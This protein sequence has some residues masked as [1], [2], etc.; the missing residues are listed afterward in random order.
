[1]FSDTADR[2]TAVAY[3]L[4][5]VVPLVGLGVVL[6][7]YVLAPIAAPNDLL[8]V[9][10][11]RW[12]LA[13]FASISIL[14]LSCFFMLRRLV[15]RSLEENRVLA[16][17]DSLTGLPN[18]RMYEDRLEQVL[19]QARRHGRLVATCFLDLDGF[20]RINDTLGHSSGDRLLC[21]VAERLMAS[22]RRSDSIAR[23]RADRGQPA[24]SRLGGDEFTFL[25]NQISDAQDAGRVAHRIL[26]ALREPFRVDHHEVFVTGSIGIA[27]FPFD[28]ADT[29]TL[30][31][32]ADTAMYWA[33]DRG[34]NNYQF[35]SRFM[36]EAAERKLELEG[37]LRRALK[38]DD[39]SLSYQPVRNTASG[40][41]VGAE[42]LLRWVDP[43]S[44]PVSPSEFVPI[45]EDTGLIVAIGEWVLRTACAQARAWQDSGLEPIRMAVNVSGHQLRQPT[46]LEAVAESLRHSGLG[47]GCLEIEI[48]ESTIMQNDGVTV[49]ACRRLDEM[50]V[51]LVLDDFGTGYSSLSTLRRFPIGRL[52]IDRSFVSDLPA[53]RDDAALTSG[54]IA[55]AHSLGLQ[56]VAEGVET[57][58]QADFLRDLGCDDLQGYLFSPAV[59]AAEFERFLHRRKRE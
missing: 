44:G 45:A 22:V 51:G 56:V 1:M 7:R 10:D 47:A 26:T 25:L 21:Q 36:N 20:K 46:F 18:R 58:E 8:A 16:Y 27:V 12:V 4:G 39:F 14:S 37:R 53:C 23:T 54:I 2:G 43:E 48:T 15:R 6:E 50:G 3:F 30:R 55:M 24:V 59:P 28:G 13:L 57:L 34:R 52:K 35:Y 5:A 33:K 32:N 11:A 38:G 49:D 31:R 41:V 17:Y 42:A 29:E 40:E 9:L 19:L